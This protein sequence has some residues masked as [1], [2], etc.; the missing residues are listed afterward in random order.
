MSAIWQTRQK[1]KATWVHKYVTDP[2]WIQSKYP[3]A[4]AYWQHVGFQLMLVVCIEPD[5]SKNK[6]VQTGVGLDEASEQRLP[7]GLRGRGVR[8]READPLLPV[9]YQRVTGMVTMVMELVLRKKRLCRLGHMTVP[10]SEPRNIGSRCSPEWMCWWPQHG[11]VKD[12]DA[13]RQLEYEGSDLT[14]NWSAVNSSYDDITESYWKVKSKGSR[15][16]GWTWELALPWPLPVS[17]SLCLLSA[18]RWE[19][20]LSH[21]TIALMSWP[22]TRDQAVTDRACWNH[23]TR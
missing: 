14:M 11:H 1:S 3:A 21:S 6:C 12:P 9:V 4:F 2:V 13:Y 17:P 19:S 8:Q 15:S 22:S 10:W 5:G 23:N 16:L 20:P 18:L 7:E